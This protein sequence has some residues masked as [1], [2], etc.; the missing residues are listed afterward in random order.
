M[1]RFDVNGLKWYL[2]AFTNATKILC[3]VLTQFGLTFEL[4]R[5]PKN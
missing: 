4:F 5:S 2:D 3:H 1:S